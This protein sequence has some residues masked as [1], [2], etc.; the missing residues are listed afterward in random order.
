MGFF[1]FR[2]IVARI[3]AYNLIVLRI[4]LV[5]TDRCVNVNQSAH[6]PLKFTGIVLRTNQ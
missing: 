3:C 6:I 1:L 4:I 5:M 2:D